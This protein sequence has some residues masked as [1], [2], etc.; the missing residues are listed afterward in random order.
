MGHQIERRD[1][2]YEPRK[3][4]TPYHEKNMP[5][6]QQLGSNETRYFPLTWRS[7]ANDHMTI[8]PL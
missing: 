7:N 2:A 5:F 3:G 8:S 6:D 4:R 1:S